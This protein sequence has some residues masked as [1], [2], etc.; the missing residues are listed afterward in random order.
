MKAILVSTAVLVFLGTVLLSAGPEPKI[1]ICHVPP[2]NPANV[3]MI[4][5]PQSAWP[6]HQAHS[7]TLPNGELIWDS[8]ADPVHGCQSEPIPEPID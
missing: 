5:I 7:G 1:T 2:G 8:E 6:A 3:Q 4:T